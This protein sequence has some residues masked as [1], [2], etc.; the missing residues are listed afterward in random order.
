MITSLLRLTSQYSALNHPW[1]SSGPSPSLALFSYSLTRNME[2]VVELDLD[3]TIAQMVS[4]RRG[5]KNVKSAAKKKTG[6]R[7]NNKAQSVVI[8]Q[9][10]LLGYEEG[11][12][13]DAPPEITVSA[14]DYSAE[15]YLRV[16]DEICELCGQAKCDDLDENE[17]GRLSSLI[18]FVR[19]WRHFTYPPRAIRFS[20]ESVSSPQGKD[21]TGGVALPQFS[22][23]SVPKNGIQTGNVLCREPSKDF[24]MYV[25]GPVSALD[26]CP[27]V[28]QRSES[29]DCHIDCEFIAIA[30]HPPESSYHKVGAPLIGRGVIQIWCLLNISVKEEEVPQTKKKAKQNQRNSSAGKVKS[31][32]PKKPRGRPR[33][34]PVDESA[35]NLDGNSDS[36]QPKKPRGRPR[37]KPVTVSL[38]NLSGN[39]ELYVQALAV[40][41]PENASNVLPT[42]TVTVNTH[43]CVAEKDSSTK[44]KACRRG[45]AADNLVLET[46]TKR[47]L[48]ALA[49]EGN[50]VDPN[51]LPSLME[52]ENGESSPANNAFL[53]SVQDP[54]E[55]SAASCVIP[56]DVALPRVVLCLAHNGKVAWDV[57]W[58]P[59]GIN[60][61][62]SKHRMGYLA[63]L[64]G[65]GALEVWEV[66]LP[67]TIKAIYSAC[68]TEGT[69][70]RFVKLE[71]VFRCS[72]LKCG[73]RQSIPLTVEWSAS[74]PHDFILA[75][76]HDGVVALWKFSANGISGDTRPLLCFS[77]D[78]VP[79]RGLAWAP[80]ES[81]F[82]GANVIVTAGHKGLKFWDIRDPF[83]P[84]WDLNPVPRN[85]YS[86][87]W[88]PDPRCVIV[89]FD[90]GTLRILSLAK[91]AYDVPVTG[92]PFVGTQQQGFHSYYCSSFAIWSVQVSRLTG[93]VA[94]CSADGTVLCF[95]LTARAV[96]KD[97]LRNRAPHFLCGSLTEGESTLTIN[98]P[99][100]DTPYPMK[101]S[102][103]EWTNAPRTMRG[104]LSAS[105]Q[106]KRAMEQTSEGESLDSQA[107]VC[108][109]DNLG[110]EVVSEDEL[111]SQKSK[112]TPKRKASGKN[113]G[114]SD[115]AL[116][117]RDEEQEDFARGES[118]KGE[119]R[120]EIEVFP[121]KI[122]AVHRVRWNMNKGS[123]RWLCSG[124]AAGIV[125]CQEINNRVFD[126]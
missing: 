121:P 99:L 23:A 90:D 46:S 18:T 50:F 69:D 114:G 96:E 88:L 105:N 56:K 52:N 26:W 119:I 66:P 76:C 98:T 87:D 81:D 104:F 108:Y 20:R 1:T 75:G 42:D 70:P 12:R 11:Q 44:L 13:D 14:F 109:G 77:A 102:L 49:R 8:D 19:E 123:E 126:K 65:N 67:R 60:D 106:A 4:K 30:A 97:P 62:E 113:K 58:R 116:V 15:N 38:D 24:V 16:V 68:H 92:K 107:L 72:K 53:S 74:A 55:S 34:K 43:E 27:R 82:E 29:S 59:S 118:Q 115:Q 39:N 124:G 7:R 94:Y 89:S 6:E 47:R 111:V 80:V 35:D 45:S 83:R 17:I 85:I 2:G 61:A 100:P 73:D 21:V 22:A 48:K 110:T 86:M 117:S 93:M 101:K 120:G 91:A 3:A 40:Q 51:H 31:P 37:N 5:K 64:L 103:N 33:K 36:V 32:N 112:Q 41:F 95:Q 9:E 63:V 71:P 84:L 28:H 79:I 25:G 57:K 122:V 125:R 10:S 78:T 54:L